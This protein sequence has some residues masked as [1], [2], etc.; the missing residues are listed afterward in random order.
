MK[1]YNKNKN[2]YIL[3]CSSNLIGKK[4]IFEDKKINVIFG[5]NASG[6]TTIA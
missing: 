5:P 3:G 1:E 4:F 6:K 2:N